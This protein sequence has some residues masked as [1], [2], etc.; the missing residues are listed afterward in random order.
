MTFACACP[1]MR[2]CSLALR[3]TILRRVS[4]LFL[5]G[6]LIPNSDSNS[7]RGFLHFC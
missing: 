3:T 4:F 2:F 6:E 5:T 7:D 1:T